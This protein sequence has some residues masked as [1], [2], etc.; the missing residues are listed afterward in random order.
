M[1]G[2]SLDARPFISSGDEQPPRPRKK[3]DLPPMTVSTAI[4]AMW[5]SDQGRVANANVQM[6]HDDTKW[7]TMSIK[8]DVGAG[9]QFS[10]QIQPISPKQRSLKVASNDA[11]AVMRTFDVYSDL[12]GGKLDIDAAIDDEKDSQPISGIIHITD[13]NIVNAP[14]LA[15]LL[16]VAALSGILDVLQ[17]E[18]ISFSTLDAPFSLTDGLFEVNDARAYGS[19]LGL[20]A[21]GQVDLDRSR[22]ALEGTVVPAYALNSVL[23]N[24]PVLGWLV[25]G[26]EKG[27]G[28]VAFN[29]TM[30][31]PTQDPSVSVNPL[32][33]LTPGFLRKLFDVFDDG[34]E[35]EARRK[36]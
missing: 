7:Q 34:S 9:K 25:T 20:T 23:G 4:K 21:K 6:S 19:A 14:A 3:D 5:V 11:G 22:L 35:T 24:I 2:A 32:S 31:G 13:Y 28:L 26:G 30:K 29:F 36:R 1:K 8:G 17:G 18:G 33:A 27:G 12:V 15:R 16:N 10:M